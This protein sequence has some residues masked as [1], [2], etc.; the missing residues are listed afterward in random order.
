MIQS[1]PKGIHYEPKMS[2]RPW[3]MQLAST[4]KTPV[5]QNPQRL[6]QSYDV[7]N[8]WIYFVL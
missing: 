3:G 1:S 5:Q 4:T 8:G 7:Y 6:Y 2:S